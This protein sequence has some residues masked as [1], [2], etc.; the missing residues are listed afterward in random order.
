MTFL[1]HIDKE[2]SY[3]AFHQQVLSNLDNNIDK[4]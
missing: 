2:L 4:G 1:V 3:L